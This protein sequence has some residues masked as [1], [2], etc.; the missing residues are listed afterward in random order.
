MHKNR[1]FYVKVVYDNRIKRLQ[2]QL[3]LKDLESKMVL[4]VGPRQSGKTWLAKEIAKSF[5]RSSYLNYDS[6]K[7]RE[8]ISAQ[9]WLPNVELLVLDELHKMPSWKNFLKGVYDTKPSTMRLLVTG[10]ARLD[11]YDQLGDS[12][13][14]RYFR[15]RL[16]PLSPAELA[17][18]GHCVDLERL[19][20]YSGFPEPFL[21]PNLLE[22][23]RWRMQ[24]TN[25]L[26]STDV[27][28]FDQIQN[29]KGM[30]LLF[31]LL[32]A[33][34]ASPVSY[35][36]LAEDIGISQ[37]TVKK[38]I[39]ILEAIYVIFRVTPYSRNIA[40]SILKE[41]KLYFFDTALVN[42][43]DGAKFENLVALSLLSY[44]YAKQDYA[45]ENYALHYLRTIDKQEVDFA[46]VHD[47]KVESII[48]AKIADVNIHKPLINF[49]DKYSFKPVQL[50]QFLN[51]EYEK[52]GI[53]FLK[54]ENYLSSL[55][56]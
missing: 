51:S 17:A 9:S 31:E 29:L 1:D 33:R 41:P 20:E 37:Q 13:A 52:K 53:S 21:A 15:H 22:A 27:F 39:Q 36:A 8:I 55:K 16:L 23:N 43:G 6:I 40:R 30:R 45:A 35:K 25:S 4:L 50:L 38:Y 26:L 14:G 56:V 49:A 46:L 54:A 2:E 47:D 5:K 3:I 19:L 42:A 18:T 7:D 34:V 44:V 24:Y 32:R 28:E 11:V 48:E 10:S 12:L